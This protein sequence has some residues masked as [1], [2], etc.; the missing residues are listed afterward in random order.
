MAFA[1]GGAVAAVRRHKDVPYVAHGAS[2]KQKLDVYVPMTK[3][4]APR[5]VVV[6]VH[7]RCRRRR[8]SLLCAPSLSFVFAGAGCVCVL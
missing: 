6:F 3:S 8:E 5:P 1:D 2:D 7:V 4:A